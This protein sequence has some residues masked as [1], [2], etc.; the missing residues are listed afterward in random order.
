MLLLLFADGDLCNKIKMMRLMYGGLL[1]CKLCVI[2]LVCIVF[3]LLAQILENPM[4][5]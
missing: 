4:V 1:S 2:F 5:D 3:S